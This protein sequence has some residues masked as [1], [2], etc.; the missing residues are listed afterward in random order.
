MDD[1]LKSEEYEYAGFW[2]RFWA[3]FID[4]IIIGIFT[5]PLTILRTRVA[6]INIKVQKSSYQ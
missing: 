6:R 1:I 2:T 5:I 3:T 4:I